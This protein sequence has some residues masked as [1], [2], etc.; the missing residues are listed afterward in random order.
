M[1]RLEGNPT[2]NYKLTLAMFFFVLA[3]SSS[4]SARRFSISCLTYKN[5]MMVVNSGSDFAQYISHNWYTQFLLY[6]LIIFKNKVYKLDSD[7]VNFTISPMILTFIFPPNGQNPHSDQ[8]QEKNT[9]KQVALWLSQKIIQF[10]VKLML[11]TSLFLKN[12]SSFLFD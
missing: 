9:L 10:F 7:F 4:L 3:N 1:K 12:I 6:H 5:T 8:I 2:D 11:I